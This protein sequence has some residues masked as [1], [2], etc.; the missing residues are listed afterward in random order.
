MIRT[1]RAIIHTVFPVPNSERMNTSIAT[2]GNVTVATLIADIIIT[3]FKADF[4]LLYK[5]FRNLCL[6][7]LL[8]I[9]RINLKLMQ[10]HIKLTNMY[11]HLFYRIQI[12]CITS[13]FAIFTL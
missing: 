11:Q 1:S 10:I 5:A 6:L 12:L 8:Y 3:I 2:V 13:F 7:N 9:I 4:Y